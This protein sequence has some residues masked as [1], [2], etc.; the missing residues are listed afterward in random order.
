LL[1]EASLNHTLTGV[2][3]FPKYAS[4]A[5]VAQGVLAYTLHATE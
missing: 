1:R 5:H 2:S 4:I 3:Q